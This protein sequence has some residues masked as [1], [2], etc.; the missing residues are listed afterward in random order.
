M[1][2]NDASTI[3]CPPSVTKA[4]PFL[5]RRSS[6][7]PLQP[8]AEAAA[9][10]LRRVAANPNGTTSMGSGK[11]PS[12]GTHLDSSAMTIMRAEEEAT[13]FSRNS[14]P[15]PPL[16]RLKSGAISSAPSMVRSRQGASSR[17]VSCT[18]TCSASLRVASDVAT[19][20]TSSPARTRSPRSLT[21]W[22][23]VEPVPSPS[24]IPGC[25][26]ASARAAAARF[27]ASTPTIGGTAVKG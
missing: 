13:I 14:A 12:A 18:P 6:I 21:K 1:R 17:V 22:R 24:R 9:S 25:T 26:N 5:P 4:W 27:C 16:I 10:I 23:A 15:P 20:I 2:P 19:A 3:Q 7:G 11:R 8:A